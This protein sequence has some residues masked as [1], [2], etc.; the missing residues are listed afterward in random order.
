MC[1]G[2]VISF[3]LYTFRSDAWRIPYSCPQSRQPETTVVIMPPLCHVLF[4]WTSPVLH[5]PHSKLLSAHLPAW[6]SFCFFILHQIVTF[7]PT[8]T[9]APA[10]YLSEAARATVAFKFMKVTGQRNVFGLFCWY[11]CADQCGVIVQPG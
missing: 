10:L 7:N 1:Y 8:H 4:I 11:T 2:H 9:T 3:R 6:V 5:S